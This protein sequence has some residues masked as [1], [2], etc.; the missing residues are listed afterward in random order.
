MSRTVEEYREV[1]GEYSLIWKIRNKISQPKEIVC[2]RCGKKG[3]LMQKTTVS[4]KIYKYRKWYVYHERIPNPSKPSLKIQSW[5]YLNRN[6]LENPTIRDRIKSIEHME[7]VKRCLYECIRI[8]D[9]EFEWRMC[10]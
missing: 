5:C 9:K 10:V 4:K 7:E 1:F 3:R 8:R 2:P 6:Q